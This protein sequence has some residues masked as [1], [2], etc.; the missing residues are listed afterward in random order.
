MADDRDL[1]IE[2]LE[3]AL[4]Q[5]GRLPE[6]RRAR[7][8]R[9]IRGGLGVAAG[10]TISVLLL[11][12]SAAA[13]YDETGIRR[14]QAVTGPG[15]A[16]LIVASSTLAVGVAMNHASRRAV[17]RWALAILLAPAL[18]FGALALLGWA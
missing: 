16:Y 14:W 18:V 8:P 1:G 3:R 15:I 7:H 2:M 11:L 4:T 12:A 9:G 6:T 17:V 10:I 5:D 13:S